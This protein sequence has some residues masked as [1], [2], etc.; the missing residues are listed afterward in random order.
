MLPST[1]GAGLRPEESCFF[2]P[3][4]LG[5]SKAVALT[6]STPFVAVEVVETHFLSFETFDVV[7]KCSR[8]LPFVVCF[9]FLA[10]APR[11]N[12]VFSPVGRVRT[13][14]MRVTYSI[15]DGSFWMEDERFEDA[16]PEISPARPG[17]YYEFIVEKLRRDNCMP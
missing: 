16:F 5:R 6:D 14:R 9:M 11:R 13:A 4:V 15:S 10:A 3:D 8:N 7:I 2:I 12:Q 1:R 17:Q